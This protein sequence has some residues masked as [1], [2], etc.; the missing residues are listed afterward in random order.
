MLYKLHWE[1]SGLRKAI[2][3]RD[4]LYA[5]LQP[6]YHA[7]NCAVTAWHCADWAWEYP[8]KDEGREYIAGLL[9][10]SCSGNRRVDSEA[11]FAAV[12]NASREVSICRQIANGSKH[13]KLRNSDPTI[14]VGHGWRPDPLA[15][16]PR[17]LDS[18]TEHFA[19]NIFER[20]AKYW[21]RLFREIGYLEAEFIGGS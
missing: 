18:D 17:I 9:E 15:S 12:C 20:A 10:F 14:R 7:Y 11:F 2:E 3:D 21:E 1:I 13:M 4:N 16:A 19:Q 6:A 8:D 5:W